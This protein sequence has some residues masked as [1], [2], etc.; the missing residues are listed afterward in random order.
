ML[1]AQR[2]ELILATVRAQGTV[3]LADLVRRLGVA[4]VTV[5]RDLTVLADRGLVDRVH[6]GVTMPHRNAWPDPVLARSAFGA[7]A[8]HALIGMVTPSVDY[9]WPQVIQGA[10]S[11]AVTAGARLVLR[12]SSYDP[13]EDRRQVSRLVERGVQTLLVAPATAGEAGA[14]LLRW[15]G[16]LP[17]PVVLMERLPPP[18]LATLALD[19]VV[20]AHAFGAGLAV[21]HLVTLGHASVGLVTSRFSPTSQALRSGWA[22]TIGALGLPAA[23]DETVP[24]Y[25]SPG[26]AGEYDEMLR[27]CLRAGVHA[28]VVHADR[29]AIGVLERA[30]DLGLSVPG[31]LAVVSYD[32]EVAAASD[33]P[34]T[35]VR[36]AK[37]RLG[38]IAA[39]L[40]LARAA[41]S[42]DRPVHRV[43]LRP[44]LMIRESCGAQPE[45]LSETHRM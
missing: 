39:E 24:A 13:A 15:L 9:Y 23:P 28:L 3:R 20:T 27:R 12:G 18:E 34:L 37:H 6:G 26:W 7:L 21:R 42:A 5:R 33:P 36:P 41:D 22:E 8:Q 16:S 17:I 11:A 38:A 35:A 44:L 30:D 1:A 32:D 29:E 25:G 10:Q 43:E 2:H 14:G 40:G 31:E 45:Q 19:A 4:P